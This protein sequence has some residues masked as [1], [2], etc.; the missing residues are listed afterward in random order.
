MQEKHP[1]VA[2]VVDLAGGKMDLSHAALESGDAGQDT[3]VVQQEAIDILEALLKD[4]KGKSGGGGGGGGGMAEAM[5]Q[6]AMG[7]GAGQNPGGNASGHNDPSLAPNTL[8]DNSFTFASRQ[9]VKDF[10]SASG[11]EAEVPADYRSLWD[12]YTSQIRKES[13]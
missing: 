1:K 6:M 5:E 13:R 3:R 8:K 11:A 10:H 4:Q 9:D 7:S 2:Q 12:A